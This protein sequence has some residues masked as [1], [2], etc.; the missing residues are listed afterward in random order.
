[1]WSVSACQACLPEKALSPKLAEFMKQQPGLRIELTIQQPTLESFSDNMD[2]I[3]TLG[4][5]PNSSLICQRIG[6]CE[7]VLA[8]A[9]AYLKENGTP[10]NPG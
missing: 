6:Q 8:A 1:M 3:V 4:S 9:P 10:G 5:L 2:L 7:V